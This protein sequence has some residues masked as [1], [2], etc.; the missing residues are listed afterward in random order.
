[1]STVADLLTELVDNAARAAGYSEVSIPLE[2]A[3]PA[4]DPRFGDYQSNHAFRLA[5]A[6]RANP[7]AVAEAVRAALPSHPAVES[8][9]V[10]GA[11]FI[12]FKLSTTWLGEELGRRAADARFGSPTPGAGR[13]LVIDYSSPNIAKRMHVGHLRSTLIG[14]A[15]DRIYRFLGFRVISDNHLGD[16]GTQ[17]GKLIVAWDRWRS[18]SAYEQ[19]AI[20]EL[21]RLYVLFGVKAKEDPALEDLARAETAKLQEG[22]AQNRALWQQFVDVSMKEFETVYARLGVSFD[23]TLGESFYR[24]RLGAVVTDLLESGVAA[25]SEGAVVVHFGPEDGKE[26]ANTALLVRKRD[27]A[28]LYG[29]TD[30]A[31]VLHRMETWGPDTIVYVTDTRQ[32]LHFKQLFATCRKMGIQLDLRHVWFGMLR[33]ADGSIAATRSAT[34][35]QGGSQLVNLIDV[36]NEAAVRARAVVDEKS[37]DLPESERAAIAEAVGAAAVRYADLSQNPQSDIVFEWDKMLALQGNTAVALLYAHARC[38]S[39]LRKGGVDETALRAIA[40]IEPAERALALHLL[41]LPEI[42]VAAGNLGRPNVLADYLYELASRFSQF[43]LACRVLDATL[44]PDVRDSRIGLVIASRQA[45]RIG[46][47]L[48]G[49]P[50]IDRM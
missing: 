36:L 38:C 24:D 37:G 48:L 33:F 9:E 49:L 15:L 41:Q 28:S 10:A 17:F 8:S 2:P 50:A 26:L 29:T 45:L 7:R 44:E 21:Q 47:G 31:T 34:G 22:D 14:S 16:W 23:V 30:V 42:A 6:M 20:A 13:S 32:Q 40:P 39:I 1:M 12:N 3:L 35:A 27:G 19:D 11:G 18:E 43:Y 46:L 4:Q 25:H 5:K